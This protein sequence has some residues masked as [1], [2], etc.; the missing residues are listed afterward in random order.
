MVE[1]FNFEPLYRPVSAICLHNGAN[2]P[3]PW[4]VIRMKGDDLPAQ[5]KTIEEIY[6]KHHPN[7]LFTASFADDYLQK[8]YAAERRTNYVVICFSIL[9]I[10]VACMGVFGLTA[11]MAEQRTKEIGIRK[12]MG[13]GVRNI[14]GLFTTDYLKLLC[15]SLVVALPVAWW[16][17]SNYLNN[18]V[19]HFAVVVDVCGGRFHH[20]SHYHC[21]GVPASPESRHGQPREINKNRIVTK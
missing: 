9:A 1:N 19:P 12:V 13:A 15:I 18:F 7:G 14:V 4:I 20:H 17:G 3:L 6:K 5:L 21:Y 11:F 16:L 8:E 10:F 2:R